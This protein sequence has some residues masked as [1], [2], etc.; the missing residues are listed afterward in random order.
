[1]LSPKNKSV[2]TRFHVKEI[3]NNFALLNSFS[4]VLIVVFFANWQ[5]SRTLKHASFTRA[6][7]ITI[8]NLQIQ[9]IAY[10]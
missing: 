1:M 3:E 9:T 2:R 10:M 5:K 6:K 7:V 8:T 4:R